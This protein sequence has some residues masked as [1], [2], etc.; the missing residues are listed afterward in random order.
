V[1]SQG[2]EFVV[3]HHREGRPGVDHRPDDLQRLPNLGPAVDEVAE[4][5][6][7]AFGVAVYA[8]LPGVAKLPEQPFEGVSVAVDVADEVVHV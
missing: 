3:T 5:D 1:K 7:L 4:E 2:I 8:L 6:R